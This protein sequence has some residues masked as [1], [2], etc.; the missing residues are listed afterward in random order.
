V[1]DRARFSNVARSKTMRGVPKRSANST[2]SQP[3]TTRWP[4]STEAV[5]G[6]IRCM[7]QRLFDPVAPFTDEVPA[8]GRTLVHEGP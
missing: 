4:S 5:S 6:S 3:P 1:N 8:Q 7:R 2:A